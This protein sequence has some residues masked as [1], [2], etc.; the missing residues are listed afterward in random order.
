MRGLAV[1]A[2][3]VVGC[4]AT[5]GTKIVPTQSGLRRDDKTFPSL[6]LAV[7]GS[8]A[9]EAE[10]RLARRDRRHSWYVVAGGLALEAVAITVAVIAFKNDHDVTGSVIVGSG[11][12][13]GIGLGLWAASLGSSANDHEHHAIEIYNAAIDAPHQ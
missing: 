2:M 12:L 10:V 9:A 4:T 7:A 1:G 8:P 3:L 11:G 13:G 6:E 5:F